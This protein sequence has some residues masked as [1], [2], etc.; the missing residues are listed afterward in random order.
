MQL[1]VDHVEQVVLPAPLGPIKAR[2]SPLL[3][4]KLTLSTACRAPKLFDSRATESSFMA[5]SAKAQRVA[6]KTA[7]DAKWKGKYEK[8]NDAAQQRVPIMG[9]PHDVVLQ[10]REHRR[11]DDWPRQGLHP[12]KED[13]HQAMI[14]RPDVDGFRG[15]RALSECE[16]STRHTAH[17]AGYGKAQPLHPFYIDADRFGA[18]WRLRPQRMA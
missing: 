9:L 15:N 12:A 17:G 3:S 1:A 5:I 4:V 11:A 8:K 7:D 6:A 16:N 13:H 2:N 10:Q 18:Q 14:D